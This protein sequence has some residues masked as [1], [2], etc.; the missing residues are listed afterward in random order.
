MGRRWTAGTVCVLFGLV[1]WT[2]CALLAQEQP[3]VPEA[4]AA[5]PHGADA[6][7]QNVI[8][9][10]W[11]GLDRS[12][13][14]E[15]LAERKLPSLAA[16]IQ[17][18][19]LQEIEVVG[20]ATV[21]KP[22]HAEML[23]GLDSQTTG[24]YSNTRFR[25]IPEGHTIFERVQQHLGGPEKVRTIMVASK[26]AH[27][28]GRGP[29]EATQW[30]RQQRASQRAA[31][32]QG[33]GPRAQAQ[34]EG[35]PFYLTRKHLDVFDAAQRNAARTGPI[36]LRYLDKYKEPRFLAFLHFSDPD[37]AGHSK[38]RDS[39]EYRAAVVACDEWLGRIV[40]W[41]RQQGLYDKTLI[42]VMTDHGFDEHATTHGNA[43]HSWLAT[44][45]RAVIRGGIIADVPATI[46]ARFGIDV[47]RL[48]PKLIG[49]PLTEPAPA[50][51]SAAPSARRQAGAGQ[52][53][54]ARRA[55][56]AAAA[57]ASPQPATP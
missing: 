40:G 16:L 7:P 15:L 29:E 33:G 1:V 23:T 30:L 44:N 31:A 49:R 28:G 54:G 39:A 50:R 18:G 12:V 13:V 43:P 14:L 37:T 22:G 17:E 42:Y 51:A 27:V 32:P 8:L 53:R 20:H 3:P 26:L 34:S 41:L 4:A 11:D 38:G 46:L 10:S 24:V 45:D 9:I 52:P 55:R 36:C 47:D 57:P 2:G 6:L 5:A 35:E 25:P 21:T 19:S 48:E 56:A